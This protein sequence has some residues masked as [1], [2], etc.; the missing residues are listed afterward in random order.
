MLIEWYHHALHSNH[1]TTGEFFFHGVHALLDAV[2]LYVEAKEH[3]A[4][5]AFPALV[6]IAGVIAMVFVT[7]YVPAQPSFT[8]AVKGLPHNHDGG[9]L[10]HLM[11][12]GILGCVLSHLFLA[13]RWKHV[14]QN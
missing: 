4:K 12:G 14:H 10:H 13:P 11:I 8:G 9:F 3:Y 7:N 1:Y 6:T 2:F 5:Y